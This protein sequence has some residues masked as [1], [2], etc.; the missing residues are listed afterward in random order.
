MKILGIN[1]GGEK[2]E[3]TKLNKNKEYI[4]SFSNGYPIPND[5]IDNRNLSTPYIDDRRGYN[6]VYFGGDN[7]YP[8]HL[9]NLYLKSSIHS[10]IINFNTN[11][12]LKNEL[13]YEDLDTSV[14]NKIKKEKLKQIYNYTF[15]KSLLLDFYINKRIHINFKNGV[16]HIIDAEK[17]RY[18]IDKSIYYVNENWIYRSFSDIVEY[19]AYQNNKKDG[20]CSYMELTK[21]VLHYPIPTYI[22]AANWIFLDSNLSYFQKQA[23]INSVNISSTLTIFED[24]ETEEEQKKFFDNLKMDY[25]GLK[26]TGKMM[27]FKGDPN[28]PETAPKFETTEPIELDKSFSSV[29]ETIVNN[30]AYAHNTAPIL[31]G[32]ATAGKL[33]STQEIQDTFNLYKNSVIYPN[34]N[35]LNSYLT[36]IAKK[37]GY[38]GNVKFDKNINLF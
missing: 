2:K 15:L 16:P 4:T 24:F 23:M 14:E 32:V 6:F 29:Q 11:I 37:Y 8:Q 20:M 9:V 3:P 21:G 19:K 34:I 12:L 27:V 13:I 10:A 33:G 26:N 18:N 36:D 5:L 28:N 7:L 38:K 30:I 25:E 1:F 35:I 17:V 31:I 22:G